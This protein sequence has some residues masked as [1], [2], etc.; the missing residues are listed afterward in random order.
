M[1]RIQLFILTSYYK[2]IYNYNIEPDKKN[3]ILVN[4]TCHL[5]LSLYMC[6]YLR[7]GPF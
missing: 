7:Q 5:I 6:V 3:I 4:I 2:F 1:S